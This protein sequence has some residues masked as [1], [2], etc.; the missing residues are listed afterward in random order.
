MNRSIN[1]I[2]TRTCCTAIAVAGLASSVTAQEILTDVNRLGDAEA[3]TV[4]NTSVG[5]LNVIMTP[6]QDEKQIRALMAMG[7][8]GGAC[9][10]VKVQHTEDAF[11]EEGATVALQQ[12]MIGGEA[13]G[14]SYTLPADQ[15]P[16]QFNAA[17]IIWG[18]SHGNPTTTQWAI[19][20]WE[21][22][23]GNG[24]AVYSESTLE[25]ILPPVNLPAS[26]GAR[27]ILLRVEVDPG[28][29]EP[30]NITN[31][32]SSTFSV[33]FEIVE[34]NNDTNFP[35]LLPPPAN[36]NAFLATDSAQPS[37][38]NVPSGNWLF[39]VD[40]GVSCPGGWDSFADCPS[41]L[42]G[43]DW[44]MRAFYTPLDCAGAG[45]CCFADGSC[46]NDFSG[47]CI[48]AGGTFL[49]AETVCAP[50]PCPQPPGAC[51]LPGG[52]SFLDQTV[53]ANMGGVFIG[54]AC[55][56]DICLG[57]CCVPDGGTGQCF[58]L[59]SNSDCTL[60]GG[61]FLGP[62]TDCVGVICFASG[63]CCINGNCFDDFDE[64]DCIN[65][66][67]VYQGDLSECSGIVC[68]EPSGACCFSGGAVCN[69]QTQANCEAL[70][71]NVWLGPGTICTPGACD[72]GEPCPWDCTPDNGDGTFGNG[73]V[74]I[75]DLLEVIN[76]F[77]G[78]GGPCDVSPDNGDGTYGNGVVNID[79]LLA[80]IN[81][82]GDCP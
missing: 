82:F 5:R 25:G 73:V 63:A 6:I 60:I 43:G 19:T 1:S 80:V 17:E 28:D 23:P 74:N 58:T 65:A 70:P 13:A 30:I 36:S 29:P 35:C 11:F 56:T 32:G 77:G 3:T 40:C 42:P 16:M 59:F 41:F 76:A 61:E 51:C 52:C 15:F 39:A 78:P 12:G 55:L 21:G 38:P 10:Q 9:P 14:A 49:G 47:S 8:G 66:G 48:S 44:V 72:A 54:G 53:C 75:D 22:T 50:N 81:N 4:I 33:S 27:F 62:Q 67:G 24:V 45:A 31:N 57:A 37:S 64:T 69:Q 46:T 26:G 18:Q 2:L 7:S 71:S 34:H 20:V 79:D 68:P